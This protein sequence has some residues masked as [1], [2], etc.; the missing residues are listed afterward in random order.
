MMPDFFGL[1]LEYRCSM[2]GRNC[3]Q[4]IDSHL[5]GYVEDQLRTSI[6]EA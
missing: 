1:I 5:K 6:N 3:L 2:K 4:S